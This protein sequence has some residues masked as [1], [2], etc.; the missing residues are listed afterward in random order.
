MHAVCAVRSPWAACLISACCCC[1]CQGAKK[2]L[3]SGDSWDD[4]KAL[5]VAA[6]CGAGA[7]LLTAVAVVPYL[8]KRMKKNFSEW[9]A[10]AGVHCLSY[11]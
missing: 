1:C 4:S 2:T 10:P 9:V 3:T 11:C 6:A 8:Y 7:A 5:W